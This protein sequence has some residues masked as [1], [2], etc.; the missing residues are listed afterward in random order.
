M[1]E[2][3]LLYLTPEQEHVLVVAL[4]ERKNS[5]NKD[6]DHEMRK[7]CATILDQVASGSTIQDMSE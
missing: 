3:I 2:G 5:Y 7:V 1:S 6:G 4:V